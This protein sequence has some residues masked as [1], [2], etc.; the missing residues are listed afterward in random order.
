M[1]EQI[2]KQT[3]DVYFKCMLGILT[4]NHEEGG[5][6]VC[7]EIDPFPLPHPQPSSCLFKE[8]T[9]ILEELL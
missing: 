7:H 6:T 1:I 4:L 9:D 3:M 8:A 5:P 2:R